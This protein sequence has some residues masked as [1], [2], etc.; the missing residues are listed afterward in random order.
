[1]RLRLPQAL[2]LATVE[3]IVAAI[4]LAAF[5]AGI[6]GQTID[7]AAFAACFFIGQSLGVAVDGALIS[8]IATTGVIVAGGIG[9]LVLSLNFSR[10]KAQQ[11]QVGNGRK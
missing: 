2:V 3:K 6:A 10:L 1:M 7:L 5:H 8:R 4:K 9:V 11:I